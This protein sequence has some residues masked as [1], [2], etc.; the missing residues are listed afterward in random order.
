MFQQNP[1]TEL[2]KRTL[3]VSRVTLSFPAPLFISKQLFNKT[4]APAPPPPIIPPPAAAP[5]PSSADAFDA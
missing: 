5:A 4:T 3:G 1:N 2:L